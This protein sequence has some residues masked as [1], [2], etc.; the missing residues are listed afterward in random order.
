MDKLSWYYNR[1]RTMSL[2]ELGYR[3]RQFLQKRQEK[4]GR[5]PLEH[6]EQDYSE[7]LRL[8]CNSK[9]DALPA[10]FADQFATYDTFTFFGLQLSLAGDIDW[11]CDISSGKRFPL[12]YAKDIDIRSDRFGSA[13]AVWEVN[14]L[15]F[16]LP[17]AARYA[18]TGDAAVLDHFM[19]LLESWIKSNP[20]L[21]GVNWYSNIEVNLRLIVW[22][23][24]WQLLWQD[25]S[26]QN[27]KRFNEFVTGLWL[28]SIYEHCVY[29]HSNPS[30]YSSANNHLVAEYAGLF[31]ASSCWQFTE[32]K[33]WNEHAL[34]GLEKELVLQ[35]SEK[36]IN[37]EQAAEYIQFITNF[38]LIPYAVGAQYGIVFSESY[39]EML[40]RICAYLTSLL[41]I[42]NNYRK[43]GDED[44]GK[45]LV[46]SADPH[47]DDFASILVSGAVLFREA[48]FK[49]PGSNYD[50]KNW[51]LWG[52]KGQEIFAGLA[53]NT[54]KAGSAFYPEEGHFFFKKQEDD[55][56]EIY[57]H[58][59]AAP[60]GFL[61]IAAH[62]HADALSIA[63][64]V[65]GFPV[66][67]DVGTYTYHT[68]A[69]WRNYFVSTLAHNTICIDGKNQAHQAGPTMW[70][71]HYKT[72]V[73]QCS[74]EPAK[75]WVGASHNGYEKWG[76]T[77]KRTIVF[78]KEK[79]IFILTDIVATNNEPHIITQPWH[80][81]PSITV[82]A[83]GQNQY[84]LK[85]KLGGRA[86]RLSF[87]PQLHFQTVQG[88][89]GPIFGWYSSSFLQKEPTTVLAGELK[90][91]GK[92]ELFFQTTI[93]IL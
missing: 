58:F 1:M 31:V 52:K 83:Q 66:I 68:D 54:A 29:S 77:H 73:H 82:S 2:P 10:E 63:L 86:V 30:L 80:L 20:Y 93:E 57:L 17:I 59:D 38:F 64:H 37:K 45:V 8:S 35:Y 67:V 42:K 34:S 89:E 15:Q 44:D 39:R 18:Q 26:L 11:H 16:L 21:Q 22:Y 41:D 9:I 51:L 62:G 71:K 48:R 4:R 14:R 27:N 75:E 46:V 56:K 55:D 81:H 3:S 7:V 23:Y 24:C 65:D 43:Y 79:N 33:K 25:A 6:T 74:K 49:L 47:F 53:V 78:E 32:S 36:G 60:L 92:Q 69:Q 85:N 19:R 12:R 61:S 5:V 13:K 90:T 40:Y 84:L 72:K 76:C 88:Q 70:L 91:A 28:P 50:F 87:D